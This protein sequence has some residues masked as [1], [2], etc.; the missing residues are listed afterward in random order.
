LAVPN[1]ITLQ[2]V[3]SKSRRTRTYRLDIEKAALDKR[4]K[5]LSNADCEAEL[6]TRVNYL[7]PLPHSAFSRPAALALVAEMVRR[8]LITG[9]RLDFVIPQRDAE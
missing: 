2:I 8:G 1:I 4:L 3:G 6:I 9:T 5:S 7:W